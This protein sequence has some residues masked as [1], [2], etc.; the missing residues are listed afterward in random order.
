[1]Y[2]S[3]I[4]SRHV[5][6]NPSSS[7]PSYL[8][9]VVSDNYLKRTT[10]SGNTLCLLCLVDDKLYVVFGYIQQLSR[11]IL[12]IYELFLCLDV[13]FKIGCLFWLGFWI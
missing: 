13:L 12:V 8:R 11:P 2:V 6:I 1:M 5:A 3:A 4:R 9:R 7:L 10:A